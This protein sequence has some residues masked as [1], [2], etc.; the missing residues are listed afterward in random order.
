MC[1]TAL[2]QWAAYRHAWKRRSVMHSSIQARWRVGLVAILV[3]LAPAG[4]RL[5]AVSRAMGAGRALSA[6]TA[7]CASPGERGRCPLAR[8]L[9][10]ALRCVAFACCLLLPPTRIHPSSVGTFRPPKPHSRQAAGVRSS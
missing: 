1:S 10:V 6:A 4:R 8:Y 5:A 3:V 7:V 9:P 2:R